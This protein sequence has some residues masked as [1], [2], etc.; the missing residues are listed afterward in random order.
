MPMPTTSPL[1][2]VSKSIGS[3]VSST[4]RGSPYSLG[5]AAAST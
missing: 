3:S 4:T 1:A 2:M 5:V